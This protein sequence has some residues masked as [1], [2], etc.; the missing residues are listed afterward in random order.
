MVKDSA[1]T[2]INAFKLAM[3]AIRLDM[4]GLLTVRETKFWNRLPVRGV[5]I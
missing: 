3:N 4:S 2:R 5:R 1:D